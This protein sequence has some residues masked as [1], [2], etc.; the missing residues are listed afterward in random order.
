MQQEVLGTSEGKLKYKD[1]G[2]KKRSNCTK[3]GSEQ[4]NCKKASELDDIP[5]KLRN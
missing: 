5:V 1:K 4:V 3:E 2:V